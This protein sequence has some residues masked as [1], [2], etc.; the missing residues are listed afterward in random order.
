MQLDL[1]NNNYVDEKD[2]H[3]RQMDIPNELGKF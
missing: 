3:M 1:K 2:Q